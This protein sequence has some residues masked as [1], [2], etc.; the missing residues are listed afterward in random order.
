MDF[1]VD[2]N[3]NLLIKKQTEKRLETKVISLLIL[4]AKNSGEVISRP[5]IMK[6]IWPDVIVGNEVIAQLIYSLRNALGDDAKFP[7]Y[8]ETIPKKGYRFMVKATLVN[9]K[10]TKQLTQKTQKTQKTQNVI[11]IKGLLITLV[12]TLL[13]ILVNQFL[14]GKKSPFEIKSILPLTQK[15]GIETD[16]SFNAAHNKMVYKH[17]DEKNTDLYLRTLGESQSI[18]LTNDSW[19]ES[20][21]LWLDEDTLIYI[22]HKAN[23]Y[24]IMRKHRQQNS[25]VLYQSSSAIIDLALKKNDTTTITFIEYDYYKNDRLNELKH[26]NLLNGNI[27]YLHEQFPNLPSAIYNPLYS[28]DGE[29]L[30][31][32]DNNEGNKRIVALNLS[33]KSY[34][35]ITEAFTSIEH[36]S[37]VDDEHLLISG[38]LSATKGVWKINIAQHTIKLLL[39]SANGQRIIHAKLNSAEKL[40]YYA[41]YKIQTDQ[42][43]ANIEHQTLEPLP[44]LNSDAEELSGIYSANGKNIYFV[45]NRTGFFELWIY[46][47]NSKALRQITKLK[48]SKIN[49]PIISPSG[50]YLAVVYQTDVLTLAIIAVQTGQIITKTKIPYLKFPLSWSHDEQSLY[51]SEHRGQVNIYQY[52]SQTLTATLIQNHAGLFAK[53]SSDAQNLMLVDYQY[54]GIINKSLTSGEVTPINNTIDR[55]T[56]L[57]PGELKVIGQSIFTVK[58]G[59]E[60]SQLYRYPLTKNNLKPHSTWLMDLPHNSSVSDFNINGNEVILSL[61]SAPQGGIMQVKF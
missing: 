13:F 6:E 52:D 54:N 28:A 49:R 56:S 43:I 20:S 15:M 47:V 35:I 31:F 41:T 14:S 36:I 39:P 55:L 33:S 61:S 45:S 51:V 60:K 37:L 25:E 48:A 9:L 29:T 40:L 57:M 19:I 21:P 50:Q 8:I 30:F 24:Q 53:E 3:A 27:E 58:K 34:N 1:T 32:I 5:Q 7:K 2:P 16:F 59:D 18:Q 10:T 22:R 11:M 38:A 17:Y 26:L 44:K 42:V 12:L 23:V 46:N 4:L